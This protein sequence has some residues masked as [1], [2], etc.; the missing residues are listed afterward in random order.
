MNDITKKNIGKII[1]N[2]LL[3][4]KRKEKYYGQTQ[5]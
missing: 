1:N 4:S 2:E 5:L 3:N